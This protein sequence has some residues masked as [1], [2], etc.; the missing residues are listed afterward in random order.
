MK[1]AEVMSGKPYNSGDFLNFPVKAENLK[2]LDTS[3]DRAGWRFRLSCS[4]DRA[5]PS[6]QLPGFPKFAFGWVLGAPLPG[7]RYWPGQ[8]ALYA[9]ACSWLPI[10]LKFSR[11]YSLVLGKISCLTAPSVL[12]PMSLISEHR[13]FSLNIFNSQVCLCPYLQLTVVKKAISLYSS[14]NKLHGSNGLIAIK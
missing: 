6:R 10:V 12:R 5:Q 1:I 3:F 7:H 2:S 4:R 14:C 13:N 8:C 11:C 9:P